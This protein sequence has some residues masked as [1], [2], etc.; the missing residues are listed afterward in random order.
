VLSH[1]QRLWGFTVRM[2][3]VDADGDPCTEV[4]VAS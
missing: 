1:L 2:E 4:L 3:T